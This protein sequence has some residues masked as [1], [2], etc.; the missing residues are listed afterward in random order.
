MK[1]LEKNKNDRTILIAFL[2]KGQMHGDYEDSWQFMVNLWQLWLI[3][4]NLLWFVSINY[5]FVLLLPESCDGD[6]QK[7]TKLSD[8]AK[9]NLRKKLK[10]RNRNSTF[11]DLIFMKF[12]FDWNYLNSKVAGEREYKGVAIGV[13]REKTLNWFKF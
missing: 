1:G 4:D 5:N 8:K 7:S 6:S 13:L 11:N 10:F 2:G 3:H 12:I 9:N